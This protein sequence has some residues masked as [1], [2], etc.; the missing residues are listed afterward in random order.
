MMKHKTDTERQQFMNNFLTITKKSDGPKY[1][2]TPS[3]KTCALKDAISL[4]AA[5]VPVSTVCSFE[6]RLISST[7]KAYKPGKEQVWECVEFVATKKQEK[8]LS[9]IKSV[10]LCGL[11]MDVI[12]DTK[13]SQMGMCAN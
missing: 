3:Q 7:N 13:R 12:S 10:G 8:T 11:Q 5:G 6:S 2:C 4:I 1:G 9:E